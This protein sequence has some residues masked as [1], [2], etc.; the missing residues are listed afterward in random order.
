MM[1]LSLRVT[2]YTRS[3][4]R[5]QFTISRREQPGVFDVV[6][7]AARR[8]RAA[9]DVR[10]VT[11]K[12]LRLLLRAGIIVEESNLSPD[13]HF[14]CA[15]EERP[16]DPRASYTL[17]RSL[18]LQ[19]SERLPRAMERLLTHTAAIA[20][21][22]QMLWVRDPVTQFVYP[23]HVSSH[24]ARQLEQLLRTGRVSSIAASLRGALVDA[25]VL[26]DRATIALERK[27]F[28]AQL[29]ACRQELR[30]R[31]YTVIRNV[32]PRFF[33]D[34][35]RRY[36]RAFDA[37][38]G[39]HKTFDGQEALRDWR[40]NEQVSRFIHPQLARMLNRALVDKIKASYAY[41]AIYRSGARLKKH[42]DRPQCRWNLSLQLDSE[43]AVRPK[44]AWPIYLE[45]ANRS[46]EVRLDVGDC[47]VYSGTDIPHWRRHLT[48]ARSST[49]CFFHFVPRGFRGPLE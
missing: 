47:V 19:R 44:D 1:E 35:V 9:V 17:N 37:A 18:W 7:D 31:R 23:L 28:E 40:Y 21:G 10:N 13:V 15:L 41:L 27:N 5:R 6:A 32:L 33:L 8:P 25:R 34:A 4:G 3:G 42:T 38:G 16:F 48:R 20:S 26:L 30:D 36:L 46:H 11:K 12:Y 49:L 2:T 24:E 14:A 45:I 22:G 39:L 29:V 43:P